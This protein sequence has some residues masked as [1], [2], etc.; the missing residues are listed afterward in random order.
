M[1]QLGIFEQDDVVE[2]E[3]EL[4]QEEK[5]TRQSKSK[6]PASDDDLLSQFEDLDLND[7]K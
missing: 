1:K 3:P 2:S 4:E 5:P 6:K 7:F